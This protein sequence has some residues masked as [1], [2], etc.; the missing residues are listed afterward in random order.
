MI[1]QP[2]LSKPKVL[3]L[4]KCLQNSATFGTRLNPYCDG[5]RTNYFTTKLYLKWFP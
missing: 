2:S 5:D 4:K 3:L 1:L